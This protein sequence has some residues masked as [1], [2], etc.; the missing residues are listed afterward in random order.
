MTNI[1]F[2][3]S[4]NRSDYVSVSQRIINSRSRWSSNCALKCPVGFFRTTSNGGMRPTPSQPGELCYCFMYHSH[5]QEGVILPSRNCLTMS[6]DSFSCHSKGMVLASSG[7]TP[8]IV[9]NIPQNT[10]Q[11]PPQRITQPKMSQRPPSC[12]NLFEEIIPCLNF[13]IA[14][15]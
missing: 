14:T 11:L 3:N 2:F 10:G 1:F 9:L 6:G 12:K 5:S 7:Q 8:K 13:L 4:G 15:G